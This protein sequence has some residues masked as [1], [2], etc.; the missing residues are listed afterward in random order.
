[1]RGGMEAI[2]DDMPKP[3]GMM[4]FA[5]VKPARGPMFSASGRAGRVS[6][7]LRRRW[8][9]RISTSDPCPLSAGTRPGPTPGNP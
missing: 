2:Y 4:A 8:P 7:S 3:V 1:M 6:P 9:N 5:P